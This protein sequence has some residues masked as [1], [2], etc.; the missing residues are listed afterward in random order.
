M[1]SF[2]LLWLRVSVEFRVRVMLGLGLEHVSVSLSVSV[3]E[4]AVSV[5]DQSCTKIKP[6]SFF[7]MEEKTKLYHDLVAPKTYFR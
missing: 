4:N 7:E 5:A 6:H 1:G 3:F 2:F